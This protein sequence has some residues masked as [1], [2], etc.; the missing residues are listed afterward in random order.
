MRCQLAF[1]FFLYLI[2]IGSVVESAGSEDCRDSDFNCPDW[3][4]ADKDACFRES[5][6]RDVCHRSCGRCRYLPRKFDASR[7]PA[8]L[9]SLAFLVGIWRSEHGGKAM[10]PTIPKFTYG[11]QLEFALS[12]SHMT[13]TPAL[14]YTYAF[15]IT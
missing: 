10:F 7:I 11:E 15:R 12:D 1:V 9:Q 14:N 4:A 2:C 8:N 6:V 5:H 13:A 3:V